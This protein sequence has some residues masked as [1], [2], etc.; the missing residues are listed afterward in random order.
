MFSIRNC[1]LKIGFGIFLL[2]FWP[3]SR[4]CSS[5]LGILI[6][7]CDM[8]ILKTVMRII[9]LNCGWVRVYYGCLDEFDCFLLGR[10]FV[11]PCD[12]GLSFWFLVINDLRYLR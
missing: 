3:K 9:G 2:D 12:V 1:G 10:E 5:N 7:D 4:V 11:W 8:L 6:C